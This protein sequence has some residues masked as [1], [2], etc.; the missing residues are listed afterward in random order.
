MYLLMIIIIL[1]YRC[2]YNVTLDTHRQCRID[3]GQHAELTI[4]L[5]NNMFYNWRTHR[6]GIAVEHRA[7]FVWSVTS[8]TNSIE[9]TRN[10]REIS[11]IERHYLLSLLYWKKILRL[12]EWQHDKLSRETL[13]NRNSLTESQET[14]GYCRDRR[15]WNFLLNQ[16][17]QWAHKFVQR[18]FLYLLNNTLAFLSLLFV[19]FLFPDVYL[20]W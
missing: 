19:F 6:Y 16:Q 1:I 4:Q 15:V 12:L 13:L 8:R 17:C 18:T 9:W 10:M 5:S 14:L 20:P 2:M 3:R 7:C 11:S